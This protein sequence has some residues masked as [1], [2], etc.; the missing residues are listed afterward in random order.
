MR[1]LGVA[2]IIPF[3]GIILPLISEIAADPAR[4]IVNF[5]MLFNI[6]IAVVFLPLTGV[7][8]KV[9]TKIF[10]DQ[11][12][13]DDPSMPKYLNEK[14]MHTPAIALSSAAR[15]TLRM[16]DVMQSMLED[17]IKTFRENNEA[18]AHQIQKRDDI[19]DKRRGSQR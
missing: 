4:Q 16:A 19:I 7:V 10:P 9:C 1:F 14:E 6:A 13:P 5:H 3:L 18:L 8:G 15:E 17:T 12:N 2:A 11:V